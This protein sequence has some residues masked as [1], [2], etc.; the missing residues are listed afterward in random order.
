MILYELLAVD[1]YST[2]RTMYEEYPG[3]KLNFCEME[4]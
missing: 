3:I 1:D 2:K 4:W